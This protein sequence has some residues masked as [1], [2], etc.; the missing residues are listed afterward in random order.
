MAKTFIIAEAGVNHNGSIEIARKLIDAAKEAGAD[1]VKFQ[2]FKTEKLVTQKASKAEYQKQT[3][4]EQESQ[5]DMIKRLELSERDHVELISYCKEKN[6]EFLSSPFDPDSAD[7]LQRIGV[8]RFKIP[9]GEIT[10]LSYLEA[11][12]RKEREV[13]QSTA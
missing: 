10:N 1:A 12:A 13:N 8:K 7:L 6:I 5:F 9:S 11:I 2:T 4:A 3:T